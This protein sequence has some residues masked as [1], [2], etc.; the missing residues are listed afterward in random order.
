MTDTDTNDLL[1]LALFKSAGDN[2]VTKDATAIL[3]WS[4]IVQDLSTHIL[5]DGE[6]D[7][8]ADKDRWMF[9]LALYK[10]ETWGDYEPATQKVFLRDPEGNRILDGQGLPMVKEI[11]TP[12]NPDTGKHYVRRSAANLL[13]Y[14]ALM[15]DYDGIRN[16][17]WA[18]ERFGR[19]AHC[20]YT[21][22]SHMKD[23]RVNKFR[24]I[25]PFATPCPVQEFELRKKAFLRFSETDDPSTVAVSRG[26]YLPQVHPRRAQFAE[27]WSGDGPWLDWTTFKAE[28]P[29]VPPPIPAMPLPEGPA[30]LWGR[31]EFEDRKS[32]V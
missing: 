13:G 3:P 29:Y 28:K 5:T 27:T 30:R 12:I 19:Y 7:T 23:G 26:F 17:P 10:D 4:Q 24:L 15:L 1:A 16:I 21:S 32:V 22:Y 14:S 9:T 2:R 18:K 6:L 31:K 8:E 11:I 25:L 20:G